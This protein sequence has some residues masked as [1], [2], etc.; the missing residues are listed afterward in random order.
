VLADLVIFG[1]II[2]PDGAVILT[3]RTTGEY[4]YANSLA[5]T[6]FFLDLSSHF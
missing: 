4:S 5:R 6:P 1:A 3:W 2:E